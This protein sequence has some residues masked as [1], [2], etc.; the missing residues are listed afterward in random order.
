M[1]IYF[2]IKTSSLT[3]YQNVSCTVFNLIFFFTE[4]NTVKQIQEIK[5]TYFNRASVYPIVLEIMKLTTYFT[6][7]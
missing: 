3:D 7:L 2:N 6:I 4:K 1:E 5:Q